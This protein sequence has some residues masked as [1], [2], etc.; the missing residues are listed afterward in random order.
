MTDEFQERVRK[1]AAALVAAGAHEVFLFGSAAAGRVSDE[2]DVDLAVAGLPPENF[3][4]A[5]GEA[6]DIL[7]RPLDLIDLDESNPFTRYLKE[8]GGLVRVD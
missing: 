2:S 8:E 1:A 6:E 3:F 7:Q 5:M 4:R